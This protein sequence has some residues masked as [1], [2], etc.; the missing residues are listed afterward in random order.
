MQV[1][2][3]CMRPS[4]P[5]QALAVIELLLYCQ[6]CYSRKVAMHCCEIGVAGDMHGVSLC[7]GAARDGAQRTGPRSTLQ[8]NGDNRPP[9]LA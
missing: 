6:L 5:Q 9:S 1:S 2:C 3:L 4:A 8:D 7:A